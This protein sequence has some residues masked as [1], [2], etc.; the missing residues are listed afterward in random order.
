M[1][2]NAYQLL[3]HRILLH[4]ISLIRHYLALDLLGCS[5]HPGYFVRNLEDLAVG[6]S[7]YRRVLDEVVVRDV[8]V[9]DFYYVLQLVAV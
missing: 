8:V 3:E 9:L 6:A 2:R 7:A 1:A 5:H 4:Q